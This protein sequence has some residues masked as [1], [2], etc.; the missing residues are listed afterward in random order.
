MR[1]KNEER[2]MRI[3]YQKQVESLKDQFVILYEKTADEEAKSK[4]VLEEKL[5]LEQELIDL[6]IDL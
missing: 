3:K 1:H 5:K 2:K 6:K 4:D